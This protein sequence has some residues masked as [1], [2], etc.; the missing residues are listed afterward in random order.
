[1]R[2]K[3][4][5]LGIAIA[6]LGAVSGVRTTASAQQDPEQSKALLGH[7]L[8]PSRRAGHTRAGLGELTRARIGTIAR[9]T[10]QTIVVPWA[11]A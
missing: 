7:Q 3:I 8:G 4:A 2:K 11:R 10:R 9:C 6:A 5:G 1:V